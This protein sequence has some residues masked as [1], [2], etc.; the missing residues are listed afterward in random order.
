MESME[1]ETL[2][3]A[4]REMIDTLD[5]HCIDQINYYKELQESLD[6]LN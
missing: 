3:D 4:K 1:A 5:N 2:E 6:E